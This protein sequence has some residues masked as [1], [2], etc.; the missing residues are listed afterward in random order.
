MRCSHC[1]MDMSYEKKKD[2]K[3]IS[4]CDRLK[5]IEDDTQSIEMWLFSHTKD[6]EQKRLET[7]EVLKDIRDLK[8]DMK[9]EPRPSKKGKADDCST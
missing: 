5:K 8:E 6:L 1:F 2:D 3:K 9:Y 7:Y 4:E